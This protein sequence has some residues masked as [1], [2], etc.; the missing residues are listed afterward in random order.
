MRFRGGRDMINQ[1]VNQFG[2]IEISKEAIAFIAGAA[3]MEC[4]G[5]VGMASQKL[6]DGLAELL[7][8]D[9]TRKG[10]EVHLEDKGLSIDVHIVVGYGTKISEV[11]K[12][13][14]ERIRYALQ[15]QTGLQVNRVNVIVQGIRVMD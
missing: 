15:L 12:N 5:L 10:I 1:M 3:A 14:M 6:Q 2:R 7:G 4:Y 8:R 13:V 9:A 11:A